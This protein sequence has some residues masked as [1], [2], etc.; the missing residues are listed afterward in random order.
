MI[1]SK[2]VYLIIHHTPSTPSINMSAAIITVPAE[3]RAKHLK[4]YQDMVDGME[5][6]ID[7]IN[8]PDNQTAEQATACFNFYMRSANF[9]ERKLATTRVEEPQADACPVALIGALLAD[10]PAP[11]A[12]PAPQG[13]YPILEAADPAPAAT[14]APAPVEHLSF[15]GV[16]FAELTSEQ[17][18]ALFRWPNARAAMYNAARAPQRK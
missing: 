2:N 6:V 11:A 3:V 13:R 4:M 12:A 9:L 10:H 8:D 17:R 7:L 5:K 14:A 18:L 1:F 15:D 16:P